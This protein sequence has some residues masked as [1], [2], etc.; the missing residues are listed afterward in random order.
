MRRCIPAR[1][2]NCRSYSLGSMPT[3]SND[4]GGIRL[5]SRAPPRG[6]PSGD[7]AGLGAGA[8]RATRRRRG[9]RRPRRPPPRSEGQA[10]RAERGDGALGALGPQRRHRFWPC[11]TRTGL[12]GSQYRTGTTL[13]RATS[14]SSGVRSGRPRGGSRCGG[15]GCRPACPRARSRRRARSSRSSDRR[16]GRLSS[17][18]RSWGTSPPNRS[19]SSRAHAGGLG[20]SFGRIRRPGSEA[21]SPGALLWRGSAHPGSGRTGGRRRRTSPRRG[22]VGTGSCRSGPGTGPRRDL[23]GTGRANR[24]GR[25]GSRAGRGATPSRSPGPAHV[26]PGRP[27]RA[28]RLPRRREELPEPRVGKVGFVVPAALDRIEH[29]ADQVVAARREQ[30]PIRPDR[31]PGEGE[32]RGDVR[33]DDDPR[34][35]AGRRSLERLD[36]GRAPGSGPGPRRSCGRAARGCRGSRRRA[37][38]TRHP[39][40]TTLSE[41][42]SNGRISAR[43]SATERALSGGVGDVEVRLRTLADP[44]EAAAPL[45]LFQPGTDRRLIEGESCGLRVPVGRRDR[46]RGVPGLEPAEQGEFEVGRGSGPAAST[47]KRCPPSDEGALP[48][49]ELLPEMPQAHA[50]A[51]GD[52]VDDPAGLRSQVPH[53]CDHAAVEDPGL[54]RAMSPRASA[55]AR[56][57]ARARWSRRPRPASRGRW[58]RRAGRRCRPRRPRRRPPGPRK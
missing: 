36:R 40:R 26:A 31:G 25:R 7:R 29:L 3:G 23:E 28:R 39:K 35:P 6:S 10:R 2:K 45:H 33:R 57:C 32:P 41:G 58:W 52:P 47:G 18:P 11:W 1:W 34:E 44:L 16:P 14:V 5:R 55:R 15:R 48:D 13:R 17:D 50:E 20:P 51:V 12:I 24:P 56:R 49:G 43:L 38:R 53:H 21:R 42:S 37:C 22:C 4:A 54:L 46:E 9:V 27:F 8:A 19:R 30:D